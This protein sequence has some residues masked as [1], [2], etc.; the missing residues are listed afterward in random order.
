MT[1]LAPKLG[2]LVGLI[3]AAWFRPGPTCRLPQTRAVVVEEI[4]VAVTGEK[5]P[6]AAMDTLAGWTG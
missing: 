5:T 4:A 2:S 6:Q 3:F 1:D